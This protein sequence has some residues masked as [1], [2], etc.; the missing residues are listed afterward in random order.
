LVEVRRQSH[1]HECKFISL[2]AGI[3]DQECRL[4]QKGDVG[5]E[6]EGSTGELGEV[7]ESAEIV[8]ETLARKDCQEREEICYSQV[9]L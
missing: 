4:S 1:A 2:V 6:E 9:D 5:A 3:I 7:L 8:Q